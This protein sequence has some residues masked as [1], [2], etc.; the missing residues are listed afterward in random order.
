MNIW[1]KKL[2]LKTDNNPKLNKNTKAELKKF[3]IYYLN[4]K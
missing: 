3:L 2:I 4:R 1:L